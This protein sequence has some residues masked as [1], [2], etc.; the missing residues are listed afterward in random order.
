EGNMMKGLGKKE[1]TELAITLAGILFLILLAFNSMKEI[2]HKRAAVEK[3]DTKIETGYLETSIAI[4]KDSV[5]EKD[6]GRDPF[7]PETPFTGGEAGITGFMLNGIVW[8]KEA[9]YAIIN[10]EV[11]K[12]G[13]KLNGASIIEI[14]ENKVILEQDGKRRTLELT[15]F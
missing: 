2:R 9:P 15:T 4:V 3:P 11:V 7:Y 14:T 1:K 13:D 6:W 5:I 12:T 8:D 10:S